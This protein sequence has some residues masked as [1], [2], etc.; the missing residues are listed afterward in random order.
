MF[1]QHHHHLS[2]QQQQQQQTSSNELFNNNQSMFR[3]NNQRECLIVAR[4]P[5]FNSNDTQNMILN[6]QSSSQCFTPIATSVQPINNNNNINCQFI[7]NSEFNLIQRVPSIKVMPPSS[8]QFVTFQQQHNSSSQQFD[9]QAYLQLSLNDHH[10][11]QQ[12]RTNFRP[13]SSRLHPNYH[14]LWLEQQDHQEQYRSNLL[15]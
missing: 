10:H 11:Q 12:Q 2:P 6:R 15:V 4:N 3:W 1:Q 13:S 5:F 8:K 7:D 14:R 9:L